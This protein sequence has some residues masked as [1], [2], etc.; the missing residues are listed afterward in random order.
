[1]SDF[2]SEDIPDEDYLY[3]R[4]HTSYGLK[5]DKIPPGAIKDAGEGMST[6]WSKYSTPLETAS[7]G[8]K[9]R[10]EYRVA[11]FLV[12]KVRQVPE[13]E[14]R[15]TPKFDN[16]AHTDIIGPKDRNSGS[17]TKHRVLLSRCGRLI[18]ADELF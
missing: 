3:Y 6:D 1:M 4:V 10:T 13:Q 8:R 15:H 2:A 11:E 18:L 9:P 5:D 7:R 14:V 17:P 16:R 12:Q